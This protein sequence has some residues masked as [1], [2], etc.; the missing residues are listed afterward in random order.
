MD[1]TLTSSELTDVF[2]SYTTQL[3]EIY[4]PR[5]EIRLKCDDKPYIIEMIKV[6]KRRLMREY[7]KNGKS[8]KYLELKKSIDESIER[9]VS[10]Y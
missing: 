6:N 2:E 5:K 1:P 10:K 3:V 4:F 9:A 8:L 7:E